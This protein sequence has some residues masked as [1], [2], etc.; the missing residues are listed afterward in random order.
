MKTSI[1]TNSLSGELQTKIKAISAAG[2]DAVEI[3]EQDFIAFEGSPKSVASMIADHGLELALFQPFRDFEG[4]VGGLRDRAFDRAKRKF[5]LMNQLG[6]DLM[7]ICSSVH[8]KALGGIDRAADDLAELG[9]IAAQWGVR[10]GYEALAWGRFVNDHRDAWEIV[11]RANHERVGLIVDSFHTLGRQLSSQ[12]LCSIPGDKIFF[13]QLAD[14]PAIDMD[15][16]HWSRH[17]RNMPGEGDLDVTGF[18]QAVWTTGYEG[19]ISLE[20]FND[21]FRSGDPFTIAVDGHRSLIALADDAREALPQAR[22]LPQSVPVSL[23][24]R[25]QVGGLSYVEFTAQGADAKKLHGVLKAM[26]FG[27]SAQHKSLDVA[28]YSQGQVNIVINQEPKGHAAEVRAI[29]GPSV[30]EVGL[31]CTDPLAVAKR[32]QALSLSQVGQRADTQMHAF[33]GIKTL[34]DGILR[35]V[36]NHDQS[37]PLW[38]GEF[39]L[40]QL[41]GPNDDG[42]GLTCVDHL[43]Q[44]MSYGE[45]LSWALLYTGLLEVEKRPVFD[46]VDPGG[47]VRSQVIENKSGTFRLTLNGA[48]NSNT[49]AGKHL[50]SGAS[51]PIQHLAF[52]SSDLRAQARR[53]MTAGFE[54]LKMPDNYYQDLAARHGLSASQIQEL[55]DLNLLYD[56]D[57]QGEFLQLYS[58]PIFNGFFFEIVQRIDG[59]SGYGGANSPFRVAAIKRALRK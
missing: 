41:P 40:A 7:L 22:T 6:T 44:S 51:A 32:A 4:L 10:V 25:G 12:S 8:P 49:L 16:L 37:A 33:P 47:V 14:A 18:L 26:G 5:D 45:M 29:S 57:D 58:Q 35:F 24:S 42:C 23:P 21:D 34:G 36:A 13:V 20:I 11:R 27:H 59:Y 54:A 38:L 55:Q 52:Q 46:V 1:A 28:L 56:Q 2:F 43:A 17:Y 30:C 15:L 9:D 39:D 3:F 53:M 48:G 31:Q 19:P 50:A